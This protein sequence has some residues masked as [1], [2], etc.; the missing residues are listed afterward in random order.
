M[1]ASKL[2]FPARFACLQLAI[3]TKVAVL[4]F[5]LVRLAQ[6]RRKQ[7]ACLLSSAY[8]LIAT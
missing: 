5:V 4:T 1:V 2:A 3:T 6:T 7:I 8:V